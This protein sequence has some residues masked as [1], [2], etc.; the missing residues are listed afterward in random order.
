MFFFILF[1]LMLGV[2]VALLG[3]AKASGD[4]IF[5][6]GAAVSLGVALVMLVL[7]AL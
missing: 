1:V 7:S 5:N 3:V 6:I 4:S 2:A